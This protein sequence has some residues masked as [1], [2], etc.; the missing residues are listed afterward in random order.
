MPLVS[1]AL[2]RAALARPPNPFAF[3]A[4]WF[5]ARAPKGAA[6]GDLLDMHAPVAGG[7]AAGGGGRALEA[8]PHAVFCPRTVLKSDQFHGVH[9]R[10]VFGKATLGEDI[11][12]FRDSRGLA[13]VSG[14]GQCHMEGLARLVQ[15][16]LAKVPGPASRA[17][18]PVTRFRGALFTHWWGRE[19]GGT[20]PHGDPQLPRISSQRAFVAGAPESKGTG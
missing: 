11:W 7:G 2:T 17:H 4:Q 10:G 16:L 5:K 15:A 9:R 8:W 12:N 3:V 13:P 20:D 19:W 18:V 6:L 14:V 1:E